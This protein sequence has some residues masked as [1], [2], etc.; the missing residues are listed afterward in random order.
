MP[1]ETGEVYP[2]YSSLRADPMGAKALYESLE[3]LPELSVS[4][5]FKERAVLDAGDAL[6]VLGVNP[7]GW[8]EIRQNVVTDYEK[9]LANGGRLVI[10]FLPVRMPS[11]APSSS[12]VLKDRWHIGLRYR[13]RGEVTQPKEVGETLPRQSALYF[14]PGAEWR[15]LETAFGDPAAVERA[16]GGGTIVLVADSFPLSNEGLRESRNAELIA[17]M[18]GKAR[19]VAFDENHFGVADTG[20]V[21]TL[22]RKYGL[23][24]GVAALI[25]AAA[26]FMWRSGSSFLPTRERAAEEAVA[27]RDAQ[28]GLTSLLRRSV[29][30][31]DLLNVCFAEWS[32]TAPAARKA[33]AVEAA[34]TARKG[35]DVAEIYRAACF[36]LKEKK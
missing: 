13:K 6:V 22:L 12:P 11:T 9:L 14:E 27:G 26:L 7:G 28:E 10:A 29:P 24:G 16:L 32:R 2:E 1:L 34:I 33:A 17:S 30:E 8:T 36:A 18:V 31:S 35:R 15:V 5:L 23:E 21:G 4:R 25:V 19:R 20:S 3:A